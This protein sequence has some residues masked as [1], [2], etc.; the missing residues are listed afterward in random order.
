MKHV[1]GVV[2]VIALLSVLSLMVLTPANLLPRQ[3]SVQAIY[4]DQLFQYEFY[5][6]AFLFALIMGL[7][8]Y[9]V[10]AFR[11]KPGDMEDA[12]HIEGNTSLELAWTA[13]PLVVVVVFAVLGSNTLANVLRPDPK[14]LEIKVTGRQWAWTFEYPDYG[15]SSDKLVL[16][17][18]MLY[19]TLQFDCN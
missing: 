8:I 4:I 16:P 11:R 2:I 13:I 17:V 9:S 15:V 14:A 5:V 7:M 12:E 3:A 6:I 18:N 10:V 1:I 19:L